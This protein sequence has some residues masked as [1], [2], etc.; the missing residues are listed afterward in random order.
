[1][2]LS[3]N[4]SWVIQDM[5]AVGTKSMIVLNSSVIYKYALCSHDT[6]NGEIKPFDGTQADRKV[7][8]HMGDAVTGNSSGARVKATICP[9]GF[10]ARNVTCAGISNDAT[11]YGDEVYATDDG[12]YTATDPGS[13]TVLGYILADADR[14][15]GKAN[16]HFRNLN[17]V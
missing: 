6:T 9:G 8:W 11:D 5:E 14:D 1:M 13:G 7:G 12:T 4:A 16:I 17:Q 10:I 15:T 3:A 2:A